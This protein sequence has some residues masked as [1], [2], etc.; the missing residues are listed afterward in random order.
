M[1][2]GETCRVVPDALQSLHPKST[3]NC[4]HSWRPSTPRHQGTQ[5]SNLSDFSDPSWC[6]EHQCTFCYFAICSFLSFPSFS[7]L[8]GEPCWIL[9]VEVQLC[10]SRWR[11]SNLRLDRSGTSF[12]WKKWRK[13]WNKICKK[14]KKGKVKREEL[15][16]QLKICSWVLWSQGTRAREKPR[17]SLAC[18][19]HSLEDGPVRSKD[20]ALFLR[21][22]SFDEEFRHGQLWTHGNLS[23]SYKSQ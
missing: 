16:W 2:Q 18:C 23:K 12:L 11:S 7:A 6:L 21:A 10:Q 8:P 1:S 22:P 14:V 5:T 9:H 19:R 15:R 3:S 20:T 13:S 17:T 4:R